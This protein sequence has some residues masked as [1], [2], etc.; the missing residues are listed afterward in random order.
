MLSQRPVLFAGTVRENLCVTGERTDAE[1]ADACRAAG[2]LD[3]V[4][5]LPGGFDAVVSEAGMSLSGGQ[6]QRL[7]LARA[8]L[9]RRPVLLVDEPTSALDAARTA[10]VMTT[11]R[12]VAED[13]IV[14]MV[15]HRVE[16]LRSTDIVV[17]LAHG[18]TTPVDYAQEVPV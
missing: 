16:D 8:L 14:V 17:R 12:H 6:R 18:R 5:A 2:L 7:A 9:A 3:E 13:R 11:L 15:T 4:R 1:L 10:D